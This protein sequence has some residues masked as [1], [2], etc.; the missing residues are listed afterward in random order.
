MDKQTAKQ[1]LEELSQGYQHATILLTAVKTGLFAAMSEETLAVEELARRLGFDVRALDIVLHALAADGLV[2]KTPE[3]FRVA[4]D[5]AP[6]LLPDSPET[7]A[8]ILAHNYSCMLR[9]I[10]LADVLRTGQPA[11]GT[12]GPRDPDS[13]R[14]FIC[15][16]ANISRIS[17]LEVAEKLDLTRYRRMLDV[18]GGPATSSIVFAR[19]NPAL[20]C[21]VFDLEE[22]IAI[23]REE[24]EE[25]GLGDR[26]ETCVGDYFKD[27][28]GEGFDLVYISNIIHSFGPDDTDMIVRK[29]HKALVDGG[30][31][32]I[33][34][35]FLDDSRT[36]PTFAALFSVNMLTGTPNGKSYSL[37]ETQDI[38]REAGFHDLSHVP[39]AA[40]SGLLIG[41]K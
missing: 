18:G 14:D 29:S 8:S 25:A 30:D 37:S 33:K 34:D 13:L 31:L 39:V 20:S 3:G 19:E 40:S 4:P 35:F 17:S 28:L 24:I 26:I 9:W 2:L 27:D 15:G 6:F 11:P 16:M 7:Q 32:V 1:R 36:S 10:A 38:L 22:T 21:V 41:R 23:A 12:L 5:F